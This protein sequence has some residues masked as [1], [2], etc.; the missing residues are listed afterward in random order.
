[1]QLSMLSPTIHPRAG[2]ILEDF[3]LLF[4]RNSLGGMGFAQ[5]PSRCYM[6]VR[7]C[8]CIYHV[9]VFSLAIR[10]VIHARGLYG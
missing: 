10:I 5:W 6:C 2:V 8:T 4:Q 7:M 3:A 9:K 1:M